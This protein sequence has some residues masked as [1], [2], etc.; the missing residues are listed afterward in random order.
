MKAKRIE[1]PI[2]ISKEE[3]E[4]VKLWDT[5]LDQAYDGISMNGLVLRNPSRIGFSEFCLLGLGEFT[6]GS[7]GWR[8]KLNPILAAQGNDI[9]NNALKFL[10]MTITLWLSLIE[11]KELGLVNELIL[12][13]GDNTSAIHWIICSSLPK[14]SVYRP[15]VLFIA[16]KIATLVAESKN[17]IMPHYLP[18]VLNSIADWLSFEGEERRQHRTGK[19]VIHPIAYDCPPNNVVSKRILS[20]FPQLVPADF[21]IS[22]LLEEVISFA[23]Q[24]IQIFESFLMLKQKGDPNHPIEYG[25]G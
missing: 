18:G 4:D 2:R 11:Y 22:H 19:P 5:L 3:I 7:Q 1:H 25:G 6:Y 9:S 14:T 21:S 15:T 12:V 23:C 10:G 8:M 13:L 16:S 17:V 20:S 24:A